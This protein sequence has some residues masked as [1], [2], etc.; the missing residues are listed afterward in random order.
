[1]YAS[2]NL[3]C[4]RCLERGLS[5]CVKIPRQ[6]SFYQEMFPQLHAN[7][8]TLAHDTGMEDRLH[9]GLVSN[10]APVLATMSGKS[11]DRDLDVFWNSSGPRVGGLLRDD[12]RHTLTASMLTLRA[13][14]LSPSLFRKDLEFWF[15]YATRT[16][17]FCLDNHTYNWRLRLGCRCPATSDL[18]MASNLL[19]WTSYSANIAEASTA[20]YFKISY[21]LVLCPPDPINS[22]RII[23]VKEASYDGYASFALDCAN[24]WLIRNGSVPPR[25]TTFAQ[26]EA[27]FT[28]FEML[29]SRPWHSGT[30]EAANATVGNLFEVSLT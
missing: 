26:R 6:T 22:Y 15:D 30:L 18:I 16:L 25:I 9:H 29:S 10:S 13:L 4:T 2:E 23:L 8:K 3:V 27:Y 28:H 14:C 19:A 20:E 12:T 7:G 5:G 24:A 1:M 11:F 17:D 21:A